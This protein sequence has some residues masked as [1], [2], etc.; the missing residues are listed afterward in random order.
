ME[1]VLSNVVPVTSGVPCG[2]M[3]GL[4]LFLF[5]IT[6][7]VKLLADNCYAIDSSND[8]IQLQEDLVQLGLWVNSWQ[9]T[10]DPHKCSIMHISSKGNTVCAKYTINAFPFN[11]VSG[12][13]YLGVSISSTMSWSDH[14]DNICTKTRKSFGFICRN[15]HNCP[16][17]M[18]KLG[19]CITCA[20]NF[21]VCLLCIESIPM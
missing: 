7:F 5:F 18:Q 21:R 15:L 12:V 6:A 14:I 11:C 10:L 3:L 13:K 8:A 4:L 16:Q 2:T 17:Y 9:M 19:L 1:V 20:S